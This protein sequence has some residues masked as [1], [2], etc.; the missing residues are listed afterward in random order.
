MRE[1][2]QDE[3]NKFFVVANYCTDDRLLKQRA[4]HE[5]LERLLW[6]FA[7]E[8]GELSNPWFGNIVHHRISY[9][10]MNRKFN[11]S[12]VLTGMSIKGLEP[13]FPSV[14][15]AERAITEV[16]EPFMEEHP[17]FVW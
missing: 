13:Y 15:V 14:E 10:S 4:M 8:N 7:C 11:V 17:D 6:R 16:I 1:G 9:D 5:T 3:D 2:E 12:A